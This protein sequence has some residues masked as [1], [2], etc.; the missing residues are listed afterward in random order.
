MLHPCIRKSDLLS[1]HT[2]SLLFFPK[3]PLREVCWDFMHRV[4]Q[5]VK[6]CL[7]AFYRHYEAVFTIIDVLNLK[8]HLADFHLQFHST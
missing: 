4:S 8:D 1:Q 7:Q 2:F 5:A 3:H 6:V